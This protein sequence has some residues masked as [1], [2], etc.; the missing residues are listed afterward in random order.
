MAV[1]RGQKTRRY[2]DVIAR[3]RDDG[4]IEPLS[5]CWP[6]GRSFQV[7]EIVGTPASDA[8][9]DAPVCTQRYTVR[10][11]GRLTHLYLERR[12]E[13]KAPPQLRWFVEVRPG[14]PLWSFGRLKAQE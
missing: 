1:P 11:G 7:D 13:G 8:F 3:W 12:T 4:R 5:V 6:D 2:V 14:H 9:P 10:I